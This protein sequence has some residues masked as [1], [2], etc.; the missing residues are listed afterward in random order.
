[1]PE[2]T[3]VM[4]V[5]VGGV[6]DLIH[7]GHLFFLEKARALGTELYVVV[8]AD[9]T[10]LKTKG[11]K[12]IFSA[13][14]RKAIVEHLKC[15]DKAIVG[16]EHDFMQVVGIERPDIIALGRNQRID[17]RELEK[18]LKEKK[19]KVKVVRLRDELAGYSTSAIIEKIKGKN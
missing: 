15:V 12:P 7:P 2:R 4:R 6:F 14:E 1:M 3:A 19:L 18:K 11:R 13:A 9:T 10:V 16:A 5:L 8:A 17:E